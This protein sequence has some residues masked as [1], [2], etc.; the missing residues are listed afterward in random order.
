M[1]NFILHYVFI[2][3]WNGLFSYIKGT[4]SHGEVISGN[5]NIK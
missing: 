1:F 4:V 5:L 3:P 2:F